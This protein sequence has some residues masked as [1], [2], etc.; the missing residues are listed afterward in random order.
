MLLHFSDN[1]NNNSF[2][3]CKIGCVK[4]VT[5]KLQKVPNGCSFPYMFKYWYNVKLAD[6]YELENVLVLLKMV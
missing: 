2:C 3:T 1:F 5:F 6:I 4:L